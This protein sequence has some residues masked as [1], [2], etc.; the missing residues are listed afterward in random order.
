MEPF[1]IIAAPFTVWIA[2]VGEAFPDVDTAPGGG[3][4]KIGTSGDQNYTEDGVVVSLAQTIEK[5]RGA[6]TTGPRKAFRTSEDMTV[7]FTLVDLTLEQLKHALNGNTVTDTA[8]GTGTPGV[9]KIGLSRGHT[10]T[11]FALLIRGGVS[12]Y[13]DSFSMQFEVPVAVLQSSQELE[14]K[15]GTPAGVLLEWAAME[16]PDASSAAERFGRLIAQDAV[17][18]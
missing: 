9:R 8:A 10:V 4:A 2:P 18:N 1:E 11:P 14:F 15:K 6:G 17:A 13:G 5:W 12:P 7:R 16:D 3:W